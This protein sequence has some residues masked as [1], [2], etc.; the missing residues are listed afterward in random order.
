MDAQGTLFVLSDEVWEQYL[1][2][3]K[4]WKQKECA[5]PEEIVTQKEAEEPSEEQA[6]EEEGMQYLNKLRELNTRI[7]GEEVSN[8]LYQLDYLL[9]RIFAVIREHPAQCPKMYKFMEYYLPTTVKLVESYADFERAGVKGDQIV[10]AKEE[11]EKTLGS[12]NEAFEKL[13]ND[14]YQNA[15]F[16]AAADAKVLKTVLA[17]DGYMRSEF[18]AD[19][20][21][22]G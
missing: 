11:I 18:S 6:I 10:S 19:A 17:Q 5:Q 15:A 2:V 22:E 8:K 13:L 20:G 21:K 4:S 9:Q 1:A 12:I 14:M 16:E 7:Q 3:Q